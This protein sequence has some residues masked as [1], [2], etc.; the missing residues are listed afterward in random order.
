MVRV[1]D[2]ARLVEPLS[3]RASGFSIA[4]AY[5]VAREVLARRRSMG[6]RRVG[7]KVG[8][9]NRAIWDEYGVYQPIFGYMHDRTVVY[10]DENPDGYSAMLP[11]E[12]LVQPRIEPEIVFR[13]REAPRTTDDAAT[14]LRRVEWVGHGFEVVHCHF[15]DWKFAAADTIADGGLHGR[16]VVGPR[17]VFE[18]GSEHDVAA[19][20]ADFQI[21]LCQDGETAAQGGGEL[22]LGSPLTALAHLAA[23]VASLPD[24]PPL[25]AG[26]LITTGTLTAAM[27]VA[28][29]ETWSTRISGL[30]LSSLALRFR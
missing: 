29:G 12:G 19:R 11:L 3:A 30:P 22:V 14:L 28:A 16:Y 27:P 25:E 20:L 4:D 26:E 5:V 10:A 1:A 15:P 24:H 2:E 9:T 23:V 17:F 21:T 7:R 8:F 13:L 18:R 6:W